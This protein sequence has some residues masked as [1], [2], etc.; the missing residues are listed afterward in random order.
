MRQRAT[1]MLLLVTLVWGATFIWMREIMLAL[2]TDLARIGTTSVV[3]FLISCRFALAGAVLPFFPSVRRH[4]ANPEVW[5]AGFALGVALLAGFLAQM[6]ALGELEP[7]TSAFLTSLY[8]VS[9]ALLSNLF[10]EGR[11]SRLLWFGVLLATLGA[12]FIEGPPHLTWGWAEVITVFCAVCFAV[13]ILLTQRYTTRMDPLALTFTSFVAVA[14]LAMALALVST[15]G[16]TGPSDL[17]EVLRVDGVLLPLLC[18]GLFGSLVALGILNL[19]Q[20]HMEPVRAA[21]IYTLEPVW[22]TLYGLVLGLVG[23]T[24]WILVGGGLLVVG[25]LMVELTGQDEEE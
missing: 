17:V 8:V 18:L 13:H 15:R 23:W 9:T 21:I 7:S 4:L 24:P 3:A 1:W 22:A 14:V 2:E 11:P 20:R 12:G 16:S 19:Y 5:K 10:G 25:N 6:T